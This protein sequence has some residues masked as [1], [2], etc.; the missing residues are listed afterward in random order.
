MALG[1]SVAVAAEERAAV[2]RAIP[3]AA[4][5]VIEWS[6]SLEPRLRELGVAG[7]RHLAFFGGAWVAQLSPTVAQVDKI[8]ALHLPS[9]ASG[10]DPGSLDGL[11]AAWRNEAQ[12]T[13]Q[14]VYRAGSCGVSVY[15]VT[16][17]S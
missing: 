8:V 12:L 6:G 3:G 1:G 7:V 2:E 13:L 17:R 10:N 16:D 11:V 5:S 14:R 9:V 4:Q 15:R